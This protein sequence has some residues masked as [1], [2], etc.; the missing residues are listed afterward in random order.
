MGV[1][2]TDILALTVA[3]LKTE[4][5]EAYN[6]VR[7]GVA[8]WPQIAS[9]IPTT[10]P[11][12]DY[13]FLGRGALMEEFKDRAR[14]Q[15][16]N[17]FN[18]QLADKTY[19]GMLEIERTALEDDQYSL[20]QMRVR[21]LA[22][23]PHRHWNQLA[24]EGLALGFTSLCYDGQLFFD[25]DHSE[26]SSGTQSNRGTSA[27][28]ADALQTTETAMMLYVDDKGVPMEI[29]PD[30]L[31]VGPKNKQV[32]WELTQSEVVV[33]VRDTTSGRQATDYA[34]YWQG[35]Y[36]VVVS[37]Y[38]RGTYDDYWFM[39]D[40]KKIVKPIVMQSRSDVPITTETDMEDG[41]SLLAELFH[42]AVRGR[43]AQG[44]GLWQT[45]FGHI[46]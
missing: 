1:V 6:A 18:Y 43:Y 21:D 45:A 46:L 42:F 19:K 41:A 7:N 31:V 32:A 26:G 3:G 29:V 5:D 16:V 36:N 2:T 22:N 10:L 44:F 4:F 27:L 9:E 33:N 15:G 14:G 12:Q 35:R 37:P 13:G 39:L 23:E 40:T 34:N 28:S 38:L 24:F 20:L 25:T 30:T 8:M 17:Q 11:I